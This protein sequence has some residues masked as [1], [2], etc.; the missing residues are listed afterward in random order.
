[1]RLNKLISATGLCSRR[2]ADELIQAQKVLV[3]GF[4]AVLGQSAEP[5]DI[6]TVD[7]TPLEH[8][9]QDVYIILN[10]PTGITCTT[11]RHV[12]GN[13]I[14]FIG[15]RERIF[16]VGRLDKDSQGLI[17]L[18]NDGDIVNQILRAEHDNKKEYVVTVNK[19]I[20]PCLIQG[21]SSGVKIYN[22][23]KNE[24]T[25]TKKCPVVK[26][27]HNTLQI[28]LSQ[29]LNRQIRRMCSALGYTVVN[30]KRIKIMN[31]SLEGL[32][33]GAWRSLTAAELAALKQSLSSFSSGGSL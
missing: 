4:V 9:K 30:L 13:I 17:L 22:P 33:L 31:L 28:T 25:V 7:G 1:M 19:P 20:T 15:H 12:Q 23:V 8:S 3:N 18:T 32:K 6:I 26:L 16:P 21:L 2:K 11:Q 10:K 27:T 5:S 14:D 29:G 24:Y